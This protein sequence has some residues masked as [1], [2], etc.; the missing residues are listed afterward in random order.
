M[1]KIISIIFA[2]IILAASIAAQTQPYVILISF[3]GF[4]W[5]YPQRGFSPNIDFMKENGVSA[6]SLNPVFPSITFPNHYS[7]ITGMYP[8]NHGIIANRFHDPFHNETYSLGDSVQV[9]NGRW[10][11]GEAFWETAGRNGIKTASYFWPGSEMNPKYRRP[12]YFMPYDGSRPFEDRVNG[13]IE[14][15]KLPYGER[16][17]FI[18]M[19]FE[20]TDHAGH[21]FG[22]DSKEVN[23]AI[24][25]DDS[26]IGLLLG[27][28]KEIQ[29][30]DS[31]DV[32]LVSDHGMTSISNKRLINIEN[33]LRDYKAYYQGSGGFMMVQP[34][35]SKVNEVY[36]LLKKNR[37]HFNVFTKDNIPD[38][39]HFSENPFISDIIIVADLGWSLIDD[40]LANRM[41]K[42]DSGGAH[43]FDNF[44]MEMNGIFFAIGPSF[45]KGYKTGTINNI[46]IYPLLCKIFNITP[47]SN[48][49]GK[50][51]NIGFILKNN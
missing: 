22:P 40:Y 5:D 18:T 34:E 15:L 13:V 9:V 1:K 8:E 42:V 44:S 10:Y 28:L 26:V 7:I 31:T 24:A 50:L 39:Y 32:I 2:I 19:Y 11:M 14:W 48:I 23:A 41:A 37:N 4:R 47:R 25:K 21:R 29:L 33:I 43:G 51:S 16:P 12:D 46:D 35:K 38:Y 20:A 36:E 6:L 45:K 17:H 49:D 27:K 3:D 30:F